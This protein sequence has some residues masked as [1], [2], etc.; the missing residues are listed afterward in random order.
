MEKNH[1]CGLFYINAPQKEYIFPQL[2]KTNYFLQPA[3]SQ[4]ET[5]NM[6]AMRYEVS[7]K[8]AR[9]AVSA[10][11]IRANTPITCSIPSTYI[12]FNCEHFRS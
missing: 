11:P 1:Y 2:V 12:R 3:H 5:N 6:T 9:S 10:R 7:E 8:H 4:Q